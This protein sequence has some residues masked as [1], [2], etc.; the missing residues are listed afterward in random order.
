MSGDLDAVQ[1]AV[2]A[3]E[4][5][6]RR[7]GIA[8]WV[9]AEPTFTD[10]FSEAPEWLTEALGPTKE[11]RAR[12]MLADLQ[13][14]VP[15]GLL[16]R[17][18]GRQYPGERQ[19][20][21]NLGLYR[22]RDGASIWT[23]PPDP[24]LLPDRP[25]RAHGLRSFWKALDKCLRRQNWASARFQSV[26]YPHLRIVCRRDGS[27]VDA[28]PQRDPR[29]VRPAIATRPLP[30]A[31]GFCDPLADEGILLIGVDSVVLDPG[32]G[33]EAPCLELPPFT[34]VTEFLDFLALVAQAAVTGE[35]ESLILAGFPPPVDAAIGWT[36]ITPDPA[37]VE[38]N[39]EPA[40]DLTTFLES[41]R[42]LY[43]VA[44]KNGL[45][46]YRL[47]Y[48]GQI[49]DS[50]GGGQLTLGGPTPEQSPFLQHPRLLPDLIRYLNQH[51]ALSY[52][53][54]PDCMGSTSQLPRPDE[55]THEPFTE[56]GLALHLLSRQEQAPA[57]LIW[58]SL[59]PFLTDLTGNTHRSEINIEKLW[60]PYLPGRGCLGLVEFRA[61]RMAPTPE[62]LTA[63]AALLRSIVLLLLQR[64]PPPQLTAWG[65]ELH[66]RFA[67]PFF[68][69]RDLWE[70]LAEL[71]AAGLGLDPVLM[72]LLLDDGYFQLSETEFA[73]C[74]IVLRRALEF[75]PLVGET[76][77]QEHGGSRLVDASTA[78]LEL[79]VR[80]PA[81][82]LD[83][84]TLSTDG[85]RV[86]L[87]SEQDW[88]GPVRVVGLRYRRYKPWHGLHPLLEPHGPVA[89]QLR[90]P[91]HP[92]ALALT[93][94]EW[95]PQGG[96]YDGLPATLAEARRRCEERCVIEW[97]DGSP[98][99]LRDPPAGAL[100]PCCLD[101]RWL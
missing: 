94:H 1:R 77:A 83:G 90:H 76:A 64:P 4:E 20:R 73:D 14:R 41:S 54:A 43:A 82:A 88:Q 78:R 92:Q 97:I 80:G 72:D 30:A 50:G 52:Y 84:W 100:T 19:P 25:L 59:A 40:P 2:R 17:T 63:L 22:R 32:T 9:G 69:R 55:R 56:L 47:H 12:D 60:N 24:L 62:K 6:V 42:G 36:T 85:C 46:P 81:E 65:P 68:L 11:S 26:V 67:L 7:Q 10:R 98:T 75:W 23:G 13:R 58:S 79:S 18:L 45:A 27:P 29:L 89:L 37:V 33:S 39:M 31:G 87:R 74:R 66:D 8:V 61:F 34:G 44:E 95:K 51:P 35:L 15:N 91:Q 93:L 3:H 96:G 70:V 28:D 101:L 16:L 57:E 21:W 49:A 53:F 99:E 48:N 5:L 71:T 38:I 86:L